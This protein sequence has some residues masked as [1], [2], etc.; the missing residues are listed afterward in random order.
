MP[1]FD[2]KCNVCNHQFDCYFSSREK[3][4]QQVPCE[5][6]KNPADKIIS[7]S[8]GIIF[9]GAGFSVIDKRIQY[10]KDHASLEGIQKEIQRDQKHGRIH[11]NKTNQ[12][13]GVN[14]KKD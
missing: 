9:N 11:K 7:S 12:W 2:Y 6:C 4:T 1:I 5:N 3:V 8:V 13:H 14:L 10:T